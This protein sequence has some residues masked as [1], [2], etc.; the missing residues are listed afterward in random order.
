MGLPVITVVALAKVGGGMDALSSP[1]GKVF[2]G[3][4]AAVCYLSVGP[5]FATPRTATVSFEVGLAPLTG[6]SP[7][8]LFLYSLVYFLLVLS[9]SMYPGQLLTPLG[10][11]WRR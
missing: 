10:A 4:L 2:G 9:V 6:E 11:S 8:A 3:L 7:L 1:I 5:L